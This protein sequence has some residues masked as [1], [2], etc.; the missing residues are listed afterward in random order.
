M[1]PICLY[2]MFRIERDFSARRAHVA[3]EEISAFYPGVKCA[4]TKSFFV[5][6]Y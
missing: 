1:L 4:A 3:W 6:F 2:H 5:Y